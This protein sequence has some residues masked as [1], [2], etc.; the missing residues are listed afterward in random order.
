M[1]RFSQPH[2]VIPDGLCYSHTVVSFAVTK[3]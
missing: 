2:L 3:V 1:L